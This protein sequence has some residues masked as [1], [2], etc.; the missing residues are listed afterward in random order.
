MIQKITKFTMLKNC[1]TSA[2]MRANKEIRRMLAVADPGDIYQKKLSNG[3][4]VIQQDQ[5]WK[6]LKK[7]TT[8][9]LDKYEIQ[10]KTTREKKFL[11]GFELLSIIKRDLPQIGITNKEKQILCNTK[12][13]KIEEKATKYSGF[14][15]GSTLSVISY[16]NRESKFPVTKLAGS[17]HPAIAHKISYKNGDIQYIEMYPYL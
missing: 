9:I 6:N 10:N 2:G 17:I 12:N 14:C 5:K 4:I 16:G 7:S 3:K 8:I 15:I 13:G 1:F 11:D